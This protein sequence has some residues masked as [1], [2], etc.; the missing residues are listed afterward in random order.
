MKRQSSK[1][2]E[3]ARRAERARG[4]LVFA[5]GLAAGALAAAA[6]GEFIL[7]HCIL[8]AAVAASGGMSLANAAVPLDPPSATGAGTRGG[9]LASL[10]YAVPF[11]AVAGYSFLQV[12]DASAARMLAALTPAQVA[13]AEQFLINPAKSPVDYFQ[14]QYVSYFFGYLLAALFFGWLFGMVG[15]AIIRRRYGA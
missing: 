2:A 4:P 10:G 5:V 6:T 9:L 13:Q 1:Q 11:M 15:G 12:N 3:Q 7:Y 8:A 14:A